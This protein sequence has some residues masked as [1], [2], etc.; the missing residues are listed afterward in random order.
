MFL[1]LF[2]SKLIH[3]MKISSSATQGKSRVNKHALHLSQRLSMAIHRPL[4]RH[5]P[6]QILHS[7][8][9]PTTALLPDVD[10]AATSAYPVS[11][12]KHY[13]STRWASSDFIARRIIDLA[14]IG[15]A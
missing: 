8:S 5:A 6:I 11:P 14:E 10:E 15:G 2:N 12:H 7:S 13:Q 3:I 4:H 1:A 9:L